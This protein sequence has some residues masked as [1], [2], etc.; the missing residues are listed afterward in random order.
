MAGFDDIIGQESIVNHMKNAIKLKKISHAYIINGESGMGKKTLARAFAM[1]LQCEKKGITP[2]M[3]CHS[4]KQC[5]TNNQPDIKWIT[6]EKPSTISVDDIREQINSDILIKPYSSEY[7]IYIMDEAEKMNV[8]AQNA[9][10]KTIEEPPSYGILM[11]LVNNKDSFLQTILSR[12][13]ALDM[14]PLSN[15]L[16]IDYMK[17]N[18][19]LP[20]YQAALMANFAAGNLGRG[21][22]LASSE[23]FLQIKDCAL[24]HM[25]GI[26]NAT[27]DKVASYAKELSGFKDNVLEYLDLLT[28]WFRDVL[29]YKASRDANEL[30]FKEEISLIEQFSIKISYNGLSEIFENIGKVNTRLKANVNFELTFTLLFM[31]IRD[32]F[33]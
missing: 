19:K 33:Q 32:N 22:R 14:K 1:T 20:D 5:L 29:I 15:D 7:K 28:S 23:N 2:C 10:L 31:S 13:V 4:C 11:L 3:E 27:A 18:L 16:I 12:C 6:H 26:G 17:R 9:L 21:I 8:A 30:I 24:N 25:K